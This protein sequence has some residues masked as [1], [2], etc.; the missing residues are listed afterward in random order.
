MDL[1][2]LHGYFLKKLIKPGVTLDV[3]GST[4]EVE[5]SQHPPSKEHFT[6][7]I[8]NLIVYCFEIVFPINVIPGV[9]VVPGR[10]ERFESIL[11]EIPILLQRE[12]DG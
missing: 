4:E 2:P 9:T 1:D 7:G 8:Q 5:R 6:L 11:L 3:V 12:L 10:R